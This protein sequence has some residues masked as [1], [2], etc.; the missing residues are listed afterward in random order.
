MPLPGEVRYI[1]GE[2]Y[3]WIPNKPDKVKQTKNEYR[4]N[5]TVNGS[6]SIFKLTGVGEIREVI[7]IANLP[8]SVNF[9][10]DGNEYFGRTA[11]WEELEHLSINSD[12]IDARFDDPNYILN[13]SRVH[14]SKYAELEVTFQEEA[15]IST[16]M[17][18]YDIWKNEEDGE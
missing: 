10:V 16:L 8:M 5:F 11:P 7:V 17:S 9:Y 18:T 13:I 1:N 4:N 15:V 2:R 12:S 6:E 14:F 3:T